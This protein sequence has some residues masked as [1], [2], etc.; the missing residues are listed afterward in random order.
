M[1]TGPLLNVIRLTRLMGRGR[2][3][4]G[5]GRSLLPLFGR[6]DDLN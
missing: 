3:F 1:Q 2:P 6:A 5:D 4:D